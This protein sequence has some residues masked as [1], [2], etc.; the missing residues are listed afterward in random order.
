MAPD[1]REPDTGAGRVRTSLLPAGTAR[2]A[3]GFVALVGLRL[4]LPDELPFPWWSPT[5]VLIVVAGLDVALALS[6]ARLEVGRD[7]PDQVALGGTARSAVIVRNPTDRRARLAVADEL[8]PS[9]RADARRWRT[10]VPARSEARVDTRIRPGRRG[11]FQPRDVVLRSIGPLGLAG[12]QG[13]ADAPGRLK[14]VPAFPSRA[15]AELR[16]AQARRLELGVRTVRLPG[17][18]TDFD[19]LREYSP[20][21]DFRR[22]DWAATAR[23]P[24]P[25]VRT[26]RAERNQTILVLLDVGRT[27]AGRVADVPRVEHLL[28]ATFALV[29]VATG[30]EDGV[31]LVA[32]DDR[33]RASLPPSHRPDQLARV[34]EA[35]YELEPALVE[36]D[37]RRA[38]RHVKSRYRRRTTVVIATDLTEAIVARTLVPALPLV[39]RDSRVFVVAVSDPEVRGWA[40]SPALDDEDAYRR[41]AATSALD[42]RA[43]LAARLR[44]L[45]V[46]VVDEPPGTLS[47]SLVDAYLKARG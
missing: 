9:L 11:R 24:T 19:Q 33:V 21:D 36:T 43:R 46:T 7:L 45:G 15:D 30:L 37:H 1:D 2:L 35:T 13:T 12:R 26:Y 47:G 27:T 25:I 41:A 16:L 29:T 18:G 31:G 17:T 20:D 5:A 23:S 6:P 10:D 32:Y 3:W 34:V 22:I 40:D 44:G 38:L 28:D 14:V 42:E 4:L 8:A 39:L